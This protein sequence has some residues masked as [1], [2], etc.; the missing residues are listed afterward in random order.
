VIAQNLQARIVVLQG[1]LS[2][3]ALGRGPI[4]YMQRRPDKR[5]QTELGAQIGQ[6]T[7]ISKQ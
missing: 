5:I 6:M 2:Y 3:K 7:A 4:N 1:K